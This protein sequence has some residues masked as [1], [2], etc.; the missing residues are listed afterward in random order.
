VGY[1]I[2]AVLTDQFEFIMGTWIT[3][4]GFAAN[5]Q[6]PNLSGFD[7]LFGPPP[8]P[9]AQSP[10]ADSFYYCQE[11]GDPSNPADYT[12]VDGIAQIVTTKGGLYVFFPSIT[13]LALIAEGRIQ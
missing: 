1:F 7:P 6:S 11:G 4:G 5:D 3:H 9:P 12:K 8:P 10:G 13:A 2:G